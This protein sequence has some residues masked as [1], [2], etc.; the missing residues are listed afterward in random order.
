MS[1]DLAKPAVSQ[2]KTE[3]HSH[4]V[5]YRAVGNRHTSLQKLSVQ[6]DL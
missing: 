6:A 5:S 4:V 3:L 2:G 1:S